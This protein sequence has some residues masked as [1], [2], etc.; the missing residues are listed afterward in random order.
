MSVLIQHLFLM[1]YGI[2]EVMDS[3]EKLTARLL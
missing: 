2:V 1:I 3:A